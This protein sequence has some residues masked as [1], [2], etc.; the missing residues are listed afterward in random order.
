MNGSIRILIVDDN[1]MMRFGLS[2]SLAAMPGV[3]VVGEAANGEEALALVDEHRPDIVTMDYKMPGDN[4]LVVTEKILKRYP[5]TR[6]ILLSAFDSEED[7]W[8]AVQVGVR[9]YLTKTAG[10]VTEL[11]EAVKAV[12]AGE[13]Y[14]PEIIAHRLKERQK[15]SGL[16]SREVEVLKLLA[17]GKSNQEIADSLDI[18][19]E[20]VKSHLLNLRSKLGAADRTQAVV[21]AYEKGILHLN[22]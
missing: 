2:G 4:G 14:F 11:L 5:D 6:I 20:T 12:A 1:Q 9:G 7:I 3:T 17:A 21:I 18:A 22:E 8:K 19:L 15:V 13:R 16:S 10:N